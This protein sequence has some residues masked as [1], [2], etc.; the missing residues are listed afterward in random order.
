MTGRDLSLGRVPGSAAWS[1]GPTPVTDDGVS[2]ETPNLRVARVRDQP[3]RRN[4]CVAPAHIGQ[5]P[6][7]AMIR[8]ET[9]IVESSAAEAEGLD[10]RAVA[11]EALALQVVEER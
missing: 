5:V 4:W 8:A 9:R 11:I 1:F 6:S 10:Q 7:I 3:A 2:T